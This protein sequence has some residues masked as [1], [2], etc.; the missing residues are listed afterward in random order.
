MFVAVTTGA[1]RVYLDQRFRMARHARGS[2]V[3]ANEEPGKLRISVFEI[4]NLERVGHVT[5]LA[6]MLELPL[7]RIL[8][9]RTTLDGNALQTDRR[10]CSCRKS[11]RR[12]LM[13]R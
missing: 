9:T 4:R 8:V 3:A 6:L 7:V 1:A 13:T 10:A 11:S 2:H 5:A 12:R